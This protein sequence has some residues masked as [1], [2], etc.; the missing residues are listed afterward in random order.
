MSTLRCILFGLAVFVL[1]SPMPAAYGAENRPF[2]EGKTINLIISTAPDG[3][4]DVTG[5]LLS[6]YLGKYLPGHP[7]IIA[8]NMAG[9]GGIVS[10]NYL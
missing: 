8:Q 1:V 2:Y 10:A 7:N 6:R 9:A 3:A 5:R 4:T